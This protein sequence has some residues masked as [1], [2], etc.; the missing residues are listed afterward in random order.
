MSCG[1]SAPADAHVT[2]AVE[3]ARGRLAHM[4]RSLLSAPLTPARMLKCDR[5]KAREAAVTETRVAL[6][7]GAGDATGSAVAKKFAWVG[8]NTIAATTTAW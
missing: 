1:L 5:C 4:E 8:L 3:A 7:V 6:I 2:S